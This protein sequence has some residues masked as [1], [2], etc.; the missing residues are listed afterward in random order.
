MR[1]LAQPDEGGVTIIGALASGHGNIAAH[2]RARELT[3]R[4]LTMGDAKKILVIDVGGTHV[5]ASATGTNER[6]KIPSGTSMT[7]KRMI[8]ALK[9]A[10]ADWQYDVVSLGYPGFVYDGRP[11]CDPANLGAGWVGFD[12][13]K[14]FDCP[15]R[16]INDAAM[17]ALGS[18]QGGRMLFLG[19]GTGLGSAMVVDGVPDAME[20]AHL[21]YRNGR[22]YE[23]YVGAAGL[24]ES[25]TKKWR[26]NARD[27]IDQ[28]VK[29][30]AADYAVLG[31]GNAARLGALPPNTMLGSN[32]NAFLGGYRLWD[33]PSEIAKAVSKLRAPRTRKRP[34]S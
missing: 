12:F 6:V 17:Q 7:A 13:T 3:R 18:Y 8:T 26:K 24:A 22:S 14:A 16:V 29:A 5:K 15:V 9:K 28:L 10:T 34:S 4:E 21:T 32:D 20:I 19:F 30:F 11:I 23:S 31:G 25:G 27:V 2:A 1:W 33:E